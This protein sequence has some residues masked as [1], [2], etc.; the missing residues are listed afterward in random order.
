[1]IRVNG[2]SSI[3]FVTKPTFKAEKKEEK[4]PAPIE[5]LNGTQA[6]ELHPL[7]DLTTGICH[8]FSIISKP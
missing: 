4:T 3:N 1:M 7:P 5:N 6:L 2:L 8:P